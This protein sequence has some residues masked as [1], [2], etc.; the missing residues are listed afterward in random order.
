V[1]V[2]QLTATSS[3]PNSQAHKRRCN[4]CA[5]EMFH[6]GPHWMDAEE[7]KHLTRREEVS[8]VFRLCSHRIDFTFAMKCSNMMAAATWY[9]LYIINLSF[10]RVVTTGSHEEISSFYV[11]NIDL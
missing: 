3:G 4:L 10:L 6:T 11:L 2:K 9:Q 5:L 8:I 7:K 1:K